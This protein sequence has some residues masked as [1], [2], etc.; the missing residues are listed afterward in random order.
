MATDPVNKFTEKKGS[1]YFTIRY[2]KATTPK[3]R[4]GT[5]SSSGP[6]IR[7]RKSSYVG[8]N[9]VLPTD[10]SAAR[11]TMGGFDDKSQYYR[12][13]YQVLPGGVIKK[14]YTLYQ[15]FGANSSSYRSFHESDPFGVFRMH[16]SDHQQFVELPSK[17]TVPLN[18]KLLEKID[19]QSIDI[20]TLKAELAGTVKHAVGYVV[21]L[22]NFAK[23][24]ISGRYSKAVK[25]Y[26]IPK[27]NWDRF[28]RFLEKDIK[29]ASD[30][31]G[32][33]IASRWVEYNFAIKPTIVDIDSVFALWRDPN[34]FL[35]SVKLRA[36][37]KLT[38]HE[39]RKYPPNL[40]DPRW[41]HN[42]RKVI[43]GTLRAVA[44]YTVADPEI[45]AAKALGLHNTTAAFYNAVP[46]SWL[47]DYVVNVGEILSL[48]TATDGLKFHHGF[49]SGKFSSQS[50]LNRTYE[51]YGPE[52][53]WHRQKLVS[54][55]FMEGYRRK[56]MYTFPRPLIQFVLPDLTLRQAS[57]AAS[58]GYLLK[59]SAINVGHY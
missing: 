51:S 17:W 11:Q 41:V 44:V 52:K 57:L 24:I 56:V 46:F 31:V 4:T 40:T 12:D 43:D 22:A 34:K 32:R 27:K 48:V 53:A 49:T 28:E 23:S 36:S 14:F 45:V 5:V 20:N 7:L 1:Q 13:G 59:R 39:E 15:Q 21:P 25:S 37:T 54:H 29:S 33:R 6:K 47:V 3:T 16:L 58:V 55:S 19:N 38:V 50:K 8:S 18:N 2:E 10:Y 30:S 9:R 42:D 26:G 35:G